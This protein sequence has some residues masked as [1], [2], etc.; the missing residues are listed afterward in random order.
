M[1]LLNMLPAIDCGNE[2]NVCSEDAPIEVES[3]PTE[4]R[5]A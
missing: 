3:F 2:E 4:I 5:G 1:H